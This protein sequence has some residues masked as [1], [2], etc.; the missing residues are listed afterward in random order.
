MNSLI[1]FVF[2]ILVNTNFFHLLFG[3]LQSNHSCFWIRINIT[4]GFLCA[5]E[6]EAIYHCKFTNCLPYFRPKYV[7]VELSERLQHFTAVKCLS[8]MQISVK[9]LSEIP[10]MNDTKCW[11][12]LVYHTAG[13]LCI[14]CTA[15][16]AVNT[17]HQNHCLQSAI[18]TVCSVHLVKCH[19]HMVFIVY[20]VSV[21]YSVQH[22]MCHV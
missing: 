7:Q 9:M 17:V 13:H 10:T 11:N 18:F 22:A 1:H 15:Q 16:V 6:L 5:I 4:L 20:C 2:T 21:I 19:R 8:F 3:I 12:H 14:P